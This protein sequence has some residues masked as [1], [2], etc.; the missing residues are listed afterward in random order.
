MFK[1]RIV[2][3]RR[4]AIKVFE[5]DFEVADAI[6]AIDG[7]KQGFRGPQAVKE[8]CSAIDYRLDGTRRLADGRRVWS[9]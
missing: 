2:K 5:D 9:V 8:A 1:E 4:M 3:Y 6:V 7:V